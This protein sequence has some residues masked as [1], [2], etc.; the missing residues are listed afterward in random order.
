[1]IADIDTSFDVTSLDDLIEKTQI[2]YQMER[3][4][5]KIDP[6]LVLDPHFS[7]TEAGSGCANGVC[8]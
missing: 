7:H 6:R 1:M 4:S 8:A 2:V 3:P 5:P